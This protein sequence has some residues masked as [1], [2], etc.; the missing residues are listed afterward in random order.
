[1]KNESNKNKN[2]KSKNKGKKRVKRDI[3]I[4]K[5]IVMKIRNI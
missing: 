1:M 4:R 3:R 2:N 5:V